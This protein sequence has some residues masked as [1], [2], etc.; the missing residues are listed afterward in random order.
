ML[1]EELKRDGSFRYVSELAY[2]FD[3]L[4]LGGE[5]MEVAL[6]TVMDAPLPDYL[7]VAAAV[8]TKILFML[9]VYQI[10]NRLGGLMDAIPGLI[11]MIEV[12]MQEKQ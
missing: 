1:I 6:K 4:N 5:P 3:S 8:K 9:A 11:G 2:G 7:S 10:G 12:A